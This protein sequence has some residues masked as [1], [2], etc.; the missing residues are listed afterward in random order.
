MWYRSTWQAT[1]PFGKF[2]Y[3]RAAGTCANALYQVDK[4]KREPSQMPFAGNEN[5]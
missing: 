2:F 3:L 5:Y 1:F 4:H